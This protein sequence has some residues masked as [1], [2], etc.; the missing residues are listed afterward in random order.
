[1]IKAIFSITPDHQTVAFK[2]TGHANAGDY[3]HDI[4]CA[5]VSVLSI[6]TVNG[7]TK[8]VHDHPEVERDAADGG[9]LL[10]THIDPGHDAQILMNTFL[11]AMEDI[12]EQYP[13]FVRIKLNE[14]HAGGEQL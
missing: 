5:A 1:M 11:N 13:N 10:V 6:S 2:L 9:Y 12:Q 7:L 8:V 3:G 4:V 14:V